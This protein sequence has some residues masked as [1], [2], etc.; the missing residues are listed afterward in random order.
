MSDVRQLVGCGKSV[1]ASQVDHIEKSIAK[2]LGPNAKANCPDDVD[3]KSGT[4]FD[5]TVTSGGESGT[6]T[7]RL[8]NDE[9]TS[10]FW[11]GAVGGTTL[12]GMV[13]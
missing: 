12:Q 10:F 1:S 2:S 3:A 7:V 5:C 13:G 6:A 4:K 11:S 9:G 8:D